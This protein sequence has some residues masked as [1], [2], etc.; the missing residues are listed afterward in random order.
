MNHSRP[1][2]SVLCLLSSLSIVSLVSA[3]ALAADAVPERGRWTFSA[4]P[5]WRSRVKIDTRGRIAPEDPAARSTTRRDMSDSAN[6]TD[7]EIVAD[8]KAGTGGIPADGTLWGVTDTRTEVYGSA[9]SD[10][11]V[12]S[13]DEEH[14]LGL[15]LQGCYDFL[16]GETWS[17]GLNLRFAGYWNMKSA[18]SGRFFDSV[19]QTD[20]YTDR[21]VFEDSDSDQPFA[22]TVDP[23]GSTVA[24]AGETLESHTLEY[25]RTRTVSTRFRSDLYQ[26]GLGPKATWTPFAGWCDSLDW[27]DVYGGVEILCNFARN[28]LEADG[29]S[30]SQT[31]CLLGFGGDIGLVGNI[32]D[33]LGIY[34]QVGY[35]WIDASDIST[36]SFRSEIDCSS[37]VVSA[38]LQMR[39]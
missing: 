23:R 35:E 21:Y 18:T 13:S 26:I 36:G 19:R 24:Y 30:S 31:D 33:W 8:P 28:R 39:F 10:Y 22:D 9:G 25:G 15:N 4:G 12:R 37:L 14:P 32:T 7:R 34:G 38:G 29:S 17:V 5:S 3:P 16:Q 11:V 6:W 1:L 20:V 27:L 2:S